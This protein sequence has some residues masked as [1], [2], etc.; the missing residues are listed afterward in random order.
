MNFFS[1]YRTV[2]WILVLLVIINVSALATLFFHLR[3]TGNGNKAAPAANQCP[4]LRQ[5]LSLA[6]GQNRRVEEINKSYKAYSEPVL[7]AILE[8]KAEL[9]QELA[10]D[11]T[12]TNH[13]NTLVNGLCMEQKRLQ[14]ANI[15]Q[16]LELK[17]VCT[18]EQTQKLA[19]IYTELYGCSGKGNCEGMGKRHRYGRQDQQAQ[20]PAK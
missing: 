20:P 16:F 14:Q 8:K 17:K 6:P 13:L 1:K 12:D 10:K 4:R 19:R 9:L 5:E 3:I 7:D 18:P 11:Q 2:V 15:R